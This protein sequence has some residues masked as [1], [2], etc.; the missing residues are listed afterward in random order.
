MAEQI[1]DFA[2]TSTEVTE[3]IGSGAE[4]IEVGTE[5]IPETIPEIKRYRGQ[6][7]P[8]KARRSINVNSLR[9]L[10]PLQNAT[11]EQTNASDKWI[12]IVIGIVVAILIGILMWRIYEWRKENKNKQKSESS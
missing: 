2:E 9:N 12:W 3:K 8:D 5:K 1:M 11:F 4:K 6:R 10:K 7:G